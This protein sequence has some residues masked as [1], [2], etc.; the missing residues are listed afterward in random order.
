MKR[1]ISKPFDACEGNN[2]HSLF[3][4][5]GGSPEGTWEAMKS[6]LIIHVIRK[7]VCCPIPV[8]PNRNL[9]DIPMKEAA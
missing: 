2:P 8:A 7:G 5:E 3:Q 6:I 4:F 1:G 9:G